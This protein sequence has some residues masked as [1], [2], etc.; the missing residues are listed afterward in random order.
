MC[1]NEFSSCVRHWRLNLHSSSKTGTLLKKS[2]GC[3]RKHFLTKIV[4]AK[5]V[6][7]VEKWNVGDHLKR[8]FPKFEADRSNP[9]GV[10]GR[11]K[12]GKSFWC[13]KLKCRESPEMRFPKV[14]GRSEPTSGA[15]I[16]GRRMM[17]PTAVPIICRLECSLSI[18]ARQEEWPLHY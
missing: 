16:R 10:N 14:W 15:I 9:G 5:N 2:S 18:S 12:F 1:G 8:V 4:V 11:S 17:S 13:W 3:W 6:L 7:G